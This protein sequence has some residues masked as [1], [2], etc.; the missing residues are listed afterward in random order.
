M[1]PR[2]RPRPSFSPTTPPAPSGV[3]EPRATTGWVYRSEAPATPAPAASG[4]PDAP[5]QAAESPA[6][7]PRRRRLTAVLQVLSVPFTFVIVTTM[8]IAR[9][10]S[11]RRP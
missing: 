7:P 11:R 4:A 1:P 2:K 5:A 6:P 10:L 9:A 8:P 3:E